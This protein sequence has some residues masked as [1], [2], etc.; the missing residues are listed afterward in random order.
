MNI[1]IIL[2]TI[3]LLGPAIVALNTIKFIKTEEIQF[4][5]C[6]LRYNNKNDVTE[7]KKQ[8]DFELI[9]LGMK[10]LPTIIDILRLKNFVKNYDIDLVH[11]HC[12]WPMVLGCFLNKKYRKIITIHNVC[13]E[14]YLYKY[15]RIISLIMANIQNISLKYY[16]KIICIS[17]FVNN[18]ISDKYRDKK[19][20]I[21]NG[22]EEINSNNDKKKEHN[23]LVFI[24][25]CTLI[26]IKNLEELFDYLSRLKNEIS[27][28]YYIIGEGEELNNL[29]KISV[30][31]ELN[32]N[33]YFLGSLSR[34]KV[35]SLVQKSDIFLFSSLSE[36]FGLAIV[37]AMAC[38][39][40]II[41]RKI[42]ITDELLGNNYPFT[43]ETYNEFREAVLRLMEDKEKCSNYLYERYLNKFQLTKTAKEYCNLYLEKEI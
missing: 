31:L 36:G 32:K 4:I 43:Y 39:T 21:Y 30:S 23:D 12:F 26:K 37:E 1:M 7:Y 35:L 38:K 10:K 8:Y 13:K 40:P 20:V 33:I 28:R 42:P 34:S 2:P 3:K 29:K 16:N 25:C 27:F 14:D 24:T 11:T 15:G 19:I 18:S 9:E 5:V 6:S 41:M 17:E 22:I